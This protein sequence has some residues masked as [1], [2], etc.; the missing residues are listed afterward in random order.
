VLGEFEADTTLTRNSDSSRSETSREDT[1]VHIEK[2]PKVLE[3]GYLFYPVAA[4]R[5]GI[6]DSVRLKVLVD[7]SGR[8]REAKV[9]AP[10]KCVQ[11]GF[12]VSALMAA[13][14]TKW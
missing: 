10:S 12:E 8:V 4:Q 6:K 9:S 14:D 13:F 5:D 1:L 2:Y 11:C 3:W 7:R